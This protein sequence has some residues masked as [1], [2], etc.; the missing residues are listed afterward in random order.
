MT[1]PS[2]ACRARL[3]TA[4]LRA[5]HI[6]YINA[7]ATSTPRGDAAENAAIKRLFGL[8]ARSLSVSSTKGATGHMLG[9][10]GA[11]EA[12]FAVLALRDQT[13]PPT[14]NLDVADGAADTAELDDKKEA[15]EA[16]EAGQTVFDLDYVPHVAKQRRV[17]A[18]LSN[19]FGFGGTNCSLVFAQLP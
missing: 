4:G 11:V 16:A 17:R 10:A 3:Q 19:S 9:A 14:L 6:D 7:H 5:E 2:S 1:A 18:V 13:V 12:A 8:H 15:S